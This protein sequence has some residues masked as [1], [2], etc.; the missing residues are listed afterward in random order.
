MS[1]KKSVEYVF[2]VSKALLADY[3][4]AKKRGKPMKGM[5]LEHINGP[6]P[7]IPEELN[8][9]TLRDSKFQVCGNVRNLIEARVYLT[10][11]SVSVG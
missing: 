4:A 7:V 11:S 5:G 2:Q 1:V 9:R 3:L 8:R 6:A 10:I